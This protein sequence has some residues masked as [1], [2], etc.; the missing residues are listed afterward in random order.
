MPN[1][2]D[3]IKKNKKTKVKALKFAFK[4][5][6]LQEVNREKQDK[7]KEWN[8]NSNKTG[9]FKTKY[10]LDVIYSKDKK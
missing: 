3:N 5:A 6:Q 7:W 2:P 4:N 10:D 1:D 8:C 9:H